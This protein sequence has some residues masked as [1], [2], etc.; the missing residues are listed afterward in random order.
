[1]TRSDPA[2]AVQ[3]FLA[4]RTVPAADGR[5][6]ARGLYEDYRRWSAGQPAAPPLDP[7]RFGQG[8]VAAGLIRHR[9]RRGNHYL[10]VRLR[11]NETVSAP[12]PTREVEPECIHPGGAGHPASSCKDCAD[13]PE[14]R[15]WRAAWAAWLAENPDSR[16]AHLVRLMRRDGWQGWSATE[17]ATPPAAR[18][19]AVSLE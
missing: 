13:G 18:D 8:A 14:L 5:E 7:R 17:T 6:R 12:R 1:M 11:A 15:G 2:A 9:D 16:E 10:G 19:A 4:E 3:R